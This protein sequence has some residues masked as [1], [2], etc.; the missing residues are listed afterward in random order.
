MGVKG[1][2]IRLCGRLSVEIGG[3]P[4]TEMLH[5]RQ[6]R[7]LLAYLVLHRQRPTRRDELI[8]AI[9]GDTGTP[10]SDGALAPVLSRLRRALAPAP[11]E[12]RDGV[13]LQ[14]PEPAW[15][16]VEAAHAALAEARAAEAAGRR[17]DLAHE[18]ARLVEPGLLPGLEASWLDA[19]RTSVEH[20]RVEALEL[21]ANAALTIDP[22]H[23]EGLARAAV[24][25]A[26]FREST[27]VALIT[28]L[29]AR[30]NIA[31]AL[32]AYDEV[33]RLLRDELGAVPGRELVA[34][35]G[36]LLGESDE[37]DQVDRRFPD[38]RSAAPR[39]AQSVTP[40]PRDL[41][42]REHE[43]RAVGDALARVTSGEGG[44]VLF[45]GP[46]GIG[47][48]RLLD[49]L[50][51]RAEEAGLQVLDAR[52]GLLER[53][54]AFGVVRQLLEPV[55]DPILM[56]GPAA[57]AL[58]ALSDAGP[59]E[60]DA[61]PAE[62]SFPILNGLFRLVERIAR[63]GA[64]VLCIDDL[65]WS[66]AASLRFTAY[67]ARRVAALP[68]LIAAS[69][70]TGEPDA[71]E[72]LLGEL[73]QEPIT[74][75]LNPRPLTREATGELIRQRLEHEPDEAFTT[76]CQDVTAGNPLL[77]RQLLGGLSTERVVPDAEHADAVRAVGPRA[78]ARTVQRRLGRLGPSEVAVARA[79]AVLGEQPGLPAIAALAEV[80][81]A[82][83]AGA[84]QALARAEIL[85]TDEP[86]GFVHPLIRDAVYG[87]L[88]AP[89][90]GLEHERAARLLAS[91]GTAP[92]RVA[93]QLLLAPP[94]GDAWVVSRLREAA[95]VAMRRG[96]PDVA[97]RLLERAQEEPPPDDQRAALAFELG[98]S[99][100]YLRGPA[101][102]EPLQRAYA[103]LTDPAERA[104]AAIRLSHLLLFVRSPQEG[105]ALAANAAD[106]LPAE[107]DDFRDGLR[108]IRLVGAAFGA[109]DPTEFRALDDIRRG[110][111]GAGPGGR[112]L[113][114][115]A[116][117]ALALTCGPADES[118][119]LARE[120][121]SGGLDMI[122]STAAIALGSAALALGDP[123]EGLDAIERYVEYAQRKREIL[124]SIGADLW[125]GIIQIWAGDLRAAAGL[126]DRAHE[127]ERLWGTKLDAVM[128]YSAAFSA[129]VQLERGD[130]TVEVSETL[131][132]V[133]AEDPRP[134][135][136]RFWLASLAELALAEGRADEALSI[137]HRL[138]PTRP[139]D[140]HPVWAP[141]R[142]LRARAL[143]QL[144]ETEQARELAREDLELARRVGAPW[145]I[146][147]GLRILAELEEP[148]ARA[149]LAADAVGL[150]GETS[151][152]LELAKAHAVLAAALA[153]DGDE[154]TAAQEWAQVG[155]LAE[156]C[157][158]DGLARE[159]AR[160][161]EATR[162]AR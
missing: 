3:E 153:G 55:A 56:V 152:R 35:H 24:A 133:H 146:G 78:V 119:A 122:E 129:L 135:G 87:E 148:P 85:R 36:R 118:S 80:D 8:E 74:L 68:V 161:L 126:L 147:R 94:R 2:L 90:R 21:A 100:A 92:E 44:V 30:G 109:V 32:Q 57:A 26:P 39:I 31:E 65:Q 130:P 107:F 127:G 131:H 124:S 50:R 70:R 27:W 101:G 160:A 103:E 86:L 110:P 120:A 9:W 33:R 116:A 5:G 142:S 162:A 67:L 117:L 95:D 15:V 111:R 79:V 108:A 151:A 136:A 41:V 106:E 47:K 40:S 93:A 4:R 145:V 69:I 75:A 17:L 19:Q 113:T 98:G 7:L 64:L 102:V 134:D 159:A 22:A 125:G 97:M 37:R 121:F 149:G 59:P 82:T 51:R 46:A 83:A 114:A 115:M 128:A 10:P 158:A 60:R 18:A 156:A 52:A 84:V 53:E 96:A 23:A 20:L 62:G 11:I 12:G 54:F 66:D 63:S 73:A 77:L 13:L 81:E 42:E 43:L 49:E 76:A 28:T 150:L 155:D 112:A 144:G 29:R 137:T 154:E 104:H 99:A 14:L 25:A 89:V 143:A 72:A 48:T 58:A 132:R 105:V 38:A 157:G 34:L 138:E 71:D 91:L 61:G 16:D 45:E 88:P 141:W 6:G 139:P 1:A 123:S 140:T